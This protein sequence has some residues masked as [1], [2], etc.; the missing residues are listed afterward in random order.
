MIRS[1]VNARR[2]GVALVMA[3]VLMATLAVVFAAVATHVVSQRL[4]LRQRERQLQAVWL[5]RAGVELAAARLLDDPA[6][7]SEEKGELVPDAKVRIAVDKVAPDLYSV[8]VEAELGTKDD[9]APMRRDAHVR[10]RRTN[11]GGVVR[12]QAVAEK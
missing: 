3:L 5:V 2:P 9:A 10:F 11:N 7:F 8:I 1:Q 6:A 12:L 4:L